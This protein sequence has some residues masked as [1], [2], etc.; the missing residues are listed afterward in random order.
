MGDGV[1]RVLSR[2]TFGLEIGAAECL[3]EDYLFV[4]DDHYGSARSTL[5]L[6]YAADL[7]VQRRLLGYAGAGGFFY[8]G[9][10][11]YIAGTPFAYISYHHL[12]PQRYGWLFAVGIIGIMGANQINARLVKRLR[13]DRLMF[14]GVGLAAVSAIGRTQ[15]LEIGMKK[16]V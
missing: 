1:A 12:S 9:L 3:R 15:K 6:E 8:A 10:F 7:L 13:S 5:L 2:R 16:R 11:A 4:F 14:F